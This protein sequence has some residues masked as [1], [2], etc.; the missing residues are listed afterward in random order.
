MGQRETP[1]HV[2][3]VLTCRLPRF[4]WKYQSMAYRVVLLNAGV[5]MQTMYLVATDVGLAGCANGSGNSRL[6]AEI[7]G[8]DP[9]EETSIG[10]FALGA[11]SKST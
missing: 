10:E 4:A 6:F 8:L 1:P 2:L 5:A 3:I 7:T 11:A 9:L